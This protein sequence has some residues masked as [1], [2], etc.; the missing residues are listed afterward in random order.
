MARM[1]RTPHQLSAL[2]A[3]FVSRRELLALPFVLGATA[4]VNSRS[5]SQQH[6]SDKPSEY[7]ARL[8]VLRERLP[9]LAEYAAESIPGFQVA[10]I[11]D[12]EVVWSH[13]YGTSTKGSGR[14]VDEDTVFDLGSLTKPLFTAAV[15][16]LRD[17]RVLDLDAPLI[18]YFDYPDVRGQDAASKVTARHVLSHTTGLPNWRPFTAGAPLKF[19][20]APGNKFG[21]SGEGFFW[22][23][24]VVEEITGIPSAR[25]VRQEVLDPLGLGRSSLVFES[26]FEAN[27]A[28]GHRKL[29]E[30]AVDSFNK[31]SAD[32]VRRA[33][34]PTK[35]DL[36]DVTYSEARRALIADSP[37]L[38]AGPSP[39]LYPTNVASTLQATA[40]DYARFMTAFMAHSGR[41]LLSAATTAEMLAPQSV[42]N[43][44]T[45]YGLGWRVE[46][47]R[48][49]KV[50]WHSGYNDG[51]HSFALGDPAG[52]FGVVVVTNSDRGDQLRWPVVHGATGF[53]SAAIL[54]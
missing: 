4:C 3:H 42:I 17:R 18:S 48:A 54:S 8:N 50:F 45:S 22:L 37:A 1:K 15:M 5:F 7:S 24:R 52:R 14:P 49:G 9:D 51:F 47:T 33:L 40:A 28:Q 26:R 6:A 25:L 10:C 36:Q 2:S 30:P 29:D 11:L 31:Q 43:R 35:Q 13:G 32:R 34:L 23:Q 19:L 21:Y 44:Y 41:S 38:A 46:Q 12:G 53:G 20:A 27:Y 16:R 39:V